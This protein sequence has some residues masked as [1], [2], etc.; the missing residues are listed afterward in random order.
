MHAMTPQSFSAIP[1]YSSSLMLQPFMPPNLLL[2]MQPFMSSPLPLKKD[3]YALYH[4]I[5]KHYLQK[6]RSSQQNPLLSYLTYQYK[7]ELSVMK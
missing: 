5:T 1:T 4:T 7:P 2:V 6:R 3:L